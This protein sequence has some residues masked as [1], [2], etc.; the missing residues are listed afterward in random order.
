MNANT[1]HERRQNNR[2]AF[3]APVIISNA[4][5]EWE[6]S[7]LDISLK[8]ALISQ[9][10]NWH[11]GK[12][13]KCILDIKLAGDD[14]YIRMEATVMHIEGGHIGFHCDHIDLESIT[15]LRRLITLNL[16][17]EALL[18]RELASLVS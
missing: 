3:D 12:G 15:N 17:D 14:I 13:S 6:S 1:T 16:A 18:E 10:H 11:N 5:G 7:T 8:G 4:E 9:P 2:I